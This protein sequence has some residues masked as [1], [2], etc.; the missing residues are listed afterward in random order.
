[1]SPGARALASGALAALL[2]LGA[3]GAALRA[4]AHGSHAGFIRGAVSYQSLCA[5]CHGAHGRGDGPHAADALARPVDLTA[6]VAP[7]ARFDGRAVAERIDGAARPA[8]HGEGELPVWGDAQLR[9]GPDGAFPPRLEELLQ[10]LEH[11]QDRR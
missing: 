10:Y 1:V 11:I 3:A 2:A 9:P 6:L 4:S 7:G 8:A 5:R